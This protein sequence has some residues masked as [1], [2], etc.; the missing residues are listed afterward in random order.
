MGEL[1]PTLQARRLRNGLTDYLT[2]TFALTDPDAYGALADF[3]GDPAAGIFKGPYVRLRLPFAPARG[4]WGVHLDWRPDGF[5]PTATR[6]PRSSDSRP[7]RS[8]VRN[9]RW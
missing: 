7:K 3:I 9:R 1:L 8:S 6:P 2:T 4:N 5:T